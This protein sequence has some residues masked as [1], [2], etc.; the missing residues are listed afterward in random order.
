MIYLATFAFIFIVSLSRIY[1]GMHS[2]LDITVGLIIGIFVTVINWFALSYLYESFFY[3]SILGNSSFISKI[4]IYVIFF[5]IY[6]YT[7]YI[8]KYYI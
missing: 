3:S 6:I 1:F 7:N 5:S 4:L 2:F 8:M